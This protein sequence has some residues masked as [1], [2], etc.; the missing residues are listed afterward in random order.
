V[1]RLDERALRCALEQQGAFAARALLSP[2][3]CQQILAEASRPDRFERT[4]QMAPKGYGTGT[5]HYFRE[6]LPPPLHE[7]RRCLYE[8]LRPLAGEHR[9]ARPYPPTLEAFFES[10]RQAG[11]RRA[12][13][14]VLCYREGGINHP[15]RDL[16]GPEW[17]PFQAL[18]LLSRRG[19]D[20]AGGEFVLLEERPDGSELRRELALS[21]G[22]LV[23][24]GSRQRRGSDRPRARAIPLRHGMNLV[25]RGLRQAA[26][27]V[28][29]LAE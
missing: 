27:L 25:T 29:H 13:S 6:P 2:A 10:C 22:D 23:V 3:E 16:Y 8:R 12:S 9:R 17:F 20:F 14:I 18:V 26:G 24:F 7:L 11:Q 21:E 19:R 28:F 1:R 4:I 5:Y 15:H